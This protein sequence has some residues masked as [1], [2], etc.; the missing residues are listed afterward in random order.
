MLP[1]SNLSRKIARA[2]LSDSSE[3][4]ARTYRLKL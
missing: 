2:A 3:S 1:V 4:A